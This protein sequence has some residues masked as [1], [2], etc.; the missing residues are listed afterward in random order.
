MRRSRVPVCLLQGQHGALW[1]V[2]VNIY[3]HC[4]NLPI[5]LFTSMAASQPNKPTMKE[6]GEDEMAGWWEKAAKKL[7]DEDAAKL[8]KKEE[9]LEKEMKR[10][11]RASMAMR[12]REAALVRKCEEALKKRL[13]DFQERT[14]K[15][16]AIAAE[17]EERDNQ[18]FMERVVKEAHLIRKRK[19][20][21]EEERKK[22]KG[23]GP[24]STQ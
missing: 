2:Q 9:E 15:L 23:K 4:S 13:K 3:R 22:K 7:R 14:M 12:A 19:E 21:E 10:E 17:K 8:K 18:I 5:N 24:C 1:W 20:E 11:E 16:W 6:D